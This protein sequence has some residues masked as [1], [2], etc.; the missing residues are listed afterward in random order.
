MCTTQTTA[1][2]VKTTHGGRM[3]VRLDGGCSGVAACT[4]TDELA[5]GAWVTIRIAGRDLSIP[6]CE[7]D[8]LG[9]SA[10]E[11]TFRPDEGSDEAYSIPL[12]GGC[13]DAGAGG[14]VR[15][16]GSPLDARPTPTGDAAV[17]PDG[18]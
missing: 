1:L 10:L 16:A 18:G 17:G 7:I 14:C 11:V 6:G 3:T 2:A 5:P 15:D 9:A 12:R 8:A 13:L 4:S